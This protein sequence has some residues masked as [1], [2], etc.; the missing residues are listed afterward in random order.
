MK[1]SR[2]RPATQIEVEAFR[3]IANLQDENRKLKIVLSYL[4]KAL[5]KVDILAY[6][7]DDGIGHCLLC[8]S[9]WDDH[10]DFCP[11][12]VVREALEMVEDE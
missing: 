9:L 2:G 1:T 3:S 8:Q 11:W 4:R 7:E 12:L 6:H 10:A 5:R